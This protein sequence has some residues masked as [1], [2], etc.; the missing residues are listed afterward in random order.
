MLLIDVQKPLDELMETINHTYYMHMLV[1]NVERGI[2]FQK[3]SELA[4]MKA[5][6]DSISIQVEYLRE[7]NYA[8]E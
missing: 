1:N 6:N 2:E 4:A 7:N 8:L 5:I 3:A